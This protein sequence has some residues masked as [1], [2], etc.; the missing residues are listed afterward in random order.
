MKIKIELKGIAAEL[1]LGNYMP[2][3]RTIYENWEEFFHY[4]DLIHESQLLA[5]Y[6]N[7]VTIWKDDE[8]V[9]HGRIPASKFRPQKSFCPAMEQGSLYLRTECAENAVYSCEFEAEEFDIDKLFFETQDYDSL[10]RVGKSFITNVFYD[11]ESKP[12]TWVSATPVGNICLLCSFEK[13]Y[14]VPLYD[15][16]N[17][18][19]NTAPNP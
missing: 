7:E 1:V 18:K 5:D 6:V 19:N 4:N 9:F 8:Q 15:A 2:K 14:L 16:V 10:F 11:G 13:G 3:D 17:K 12:L